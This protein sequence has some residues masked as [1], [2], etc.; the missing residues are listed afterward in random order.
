MA[1]IAVNVWDFGPLETVVP[2]LHKGLIST[3]KIYFKTIFRI[4]KISHKTHY[5]NQHYT[6]YH[7]I[8]SRMG[9]S[10]YNSNLRTSYFLFA[11]FS[12][13]W[14]ISIILF[15]VVVNVENP[16]SRRHYSGSI[17]FAVFA[18]SQDGL[19]S[20]EKASWSASEL[21]IKSRLRYD[22]L[23][24]F[25]VK[26]DWTEVSWSELRKSMY[27]NWLHC[28]QRKKPQIVHAIHASRSIEKPK[29]LKRSRKTWPNCD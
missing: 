17:I 15:T 28:R 20:R 6:N 29:C 4:F 11:L 5:A 27:W 3:A 22:N 1:N 13:K 9:R 21:H 23:I 16:P 14:M 18:P 8:R 24:C 10:K 19:I 25:C 26:I 2:L 12:V 7:E